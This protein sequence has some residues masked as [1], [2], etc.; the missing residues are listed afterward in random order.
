MPVISWTERQVSVNATP[1]PYS[2][3]DGGAAIGNAL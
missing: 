3:G 1:Q 2:S